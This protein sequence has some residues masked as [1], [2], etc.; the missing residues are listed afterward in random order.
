MIKNLVFHIGDPKNGSSS[1][2]QAM[3]MRACHPEGISYVCQEELNASAMAYSIDPKRRATQEQGKKRRKLLFSQKAEWAKTHEADLG[4]ISAE[5]FSAVPPKALIKAL[6]DFMPQ[7]TETARIIAY[8]RPHA[9]RALSG[10]A[11]RVKTGT[12]LCTL[13]ESIEGQKE[14]RMLQYAPR[15]LRWRNKFGDHFTLRP[16]LRSEMRDGDVVADFF[17]TV[18]GDTPFTLD[19]IPST[20]ESLSLEEV[21]AMRRVQGRLVADEVPEFMRLSLGGCIG[22]LLT[23]MPGRY[24]TKMALS[25]AHAEVLKALFWED[26]T[27]LDQMFFGRPLM[28]EALDSAVEAGLAQ[29]QSLEPLD[30][31]PEARLRRME[32]IAGE[33]AVLV[34]AEPRGW[35]LEYQR[36]IGQRLD[37]IKDQP[38]PEALKENADRVWT[39][40]DDLIGDMLPPAAAE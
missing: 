34:N 22:R 38:N 7:Y 4:L 21:A 36:R 31:Y 24:Q 39:L 25:R 11:Q 5:F 9:G 29:G 2:Q 35:R 3:K 23:G 10:Y 28:S 40:L 20:N 13:D 18:L 12:E 37:R 17:A 1:I 15:F 16:F 6:E 33:I 26:A 32:E 19:A 14:R 30:Y 27:Q 8:V